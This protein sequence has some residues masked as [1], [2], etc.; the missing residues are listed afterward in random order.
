M[1]SGIK[2]KPRYPEILQK[3]ISI[4][5]ILRSGFLFDNVGNKSPANTSDKVNNANSNPA[6]IFVLPKSIKYGGNHA[7]TQV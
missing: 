7:N 3:M 6:W 2:I 4:R 5:I 1:D